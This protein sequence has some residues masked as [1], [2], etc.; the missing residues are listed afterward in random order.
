MPLVKRFAIRIRFHS[1]GLALP[2]RLYRTLETKAEFLV[3]NQHKIKLYSSL[4]YDYTFISKAS[5]LRR[6][7]QNKNTNL[8]DV[9]IIGAIIKRDVEEKIKTESIRA[10]IKKGGTE[11]IKGCD[12]ERVTKERKKSETLLDAARRIGAVSFARQPPEIHT[13]DKTSGIAPISLG[14]IL[15]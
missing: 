5:I 11:F 7:I 4:G 1:F 6:L 3:R 8:N 9:G 12:I 2:R 10:G 14:Y 15:P 13:L